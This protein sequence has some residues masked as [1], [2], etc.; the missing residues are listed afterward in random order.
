MIY[1]DTSF[2]A[3]A[4]GLDANTTAARGFIEANKPCLPLGFL[5]WPER[6]K[7]FWTSHPG[8]AEQL[9]DWV[10]G[11][12]AGRKNHARWKWKRSWSLAAPPD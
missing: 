12:L 11:D 2:I 5:H 3:S 6:A 10:K 4:Y 7:A 9:W 1:P 8:Q